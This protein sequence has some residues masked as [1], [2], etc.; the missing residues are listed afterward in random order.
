MALHPLLRGELPLSCGCTPGLRSLA[1]PAGTGCT[2]QAAPLLPK[3]PLL[4][5]CQGQSNS[6]AP[7]GPTSQPHGLAWQGLLCL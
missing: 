5:E 4:T 2:S 3:H 6:P 7:Q 1:E